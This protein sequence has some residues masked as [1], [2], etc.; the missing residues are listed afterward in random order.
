MNRPRR[1]GLLALAVCLLAVALINMASRDDEPGVRWYRGQVGTPV[2]SP[3]FDITVHEVELARTV[4]D[5]RNELTTPGVLVI[6]HWSV[7]A[8]GERAFVTDVELV[9]QTGLIVSERADMATYAGLPPTEAGFTSTGSSV[10]EVHPED[11]ARASLRV[12]GN[13][14]L[15]YT[16]GGGIEIG[17]LVAADAA[18]AEKV[19]LVDA[20][21]EVT[22]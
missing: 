6:V 10:F 15:F 21:T 1:Q 8:K 22:Q 3:A 9:T 7:S 19:T 5:E 12:G 16:F 18:I 13:K 4:T 20:T 11:L 17:P 14:G 2:T